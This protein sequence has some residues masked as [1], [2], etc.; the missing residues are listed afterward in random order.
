[1]YCLSGQYSIAF[2]EPARD[3]R[4]ERLVRR[5]GQIIDDARLEQREQLRQMASDLLTEKTHR[6]SDADEQQEAN[7]RAAAP[8]P[9][10]LAILPLA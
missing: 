2:V 5:I 6:S 8:P 7:A 4:I 3:R 1:M 10:V 9:N